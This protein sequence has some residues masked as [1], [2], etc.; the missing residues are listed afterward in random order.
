MFGIRYSPVAS[1]HL[2]FYPT[3]GSLTIQG[4][5][6][7]YSLWYLF[8]FMSSWSLHNN[9]SSLGWWR[10]WWSES[11]AK[12]LASHS[13]KWEI[14]LIKCYLLWQQPLIWPETDALVKGTRPTALKEDYWPVA[15]HCRSLYLQILLPQ[16]SPPHPSIYPSIFSSTHSPITSFIHPSM[17]LSS[18]LF[19]YLPHPPTYLSILSIHPPSTIP[20]YP[21]ITSIHYSIHP[22]THLPIFPVIYSFVPFIHLSIH[23]MPI[24][25]SI[26][27]SIH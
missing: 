5:K 12:C 4:D 2:G 15:S 1:Q 25:P 8:F 16:H 13:F 11:W 21:S 14:H 27:P 17:Y 3:L 9:Q 20:I 19:I 18:Y 7:F 6:A 26:H 22:P 10:N 23:I 24:H